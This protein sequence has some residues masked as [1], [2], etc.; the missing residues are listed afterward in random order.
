MK[1]IFSNGWI[2]IFHPAFGQEWSRLN[3]RYDLLK[4][5]LPKQKFLTHSDVKLL[6]ALD[7]GIREIIPDN[8]L[9]SD[10]ALHSS[11]QKY[12]RL[13]KKGL[14]GRYRLFFKVFDRERVEEK[15]RKFIDSI[16]NVTD[17]KEPIKGIIFI[18]WL[19]FPRKEGDKRDCYRVFKQK[20]K[21][22]EFSPSIPRLLEECYSQEDFRQEEINNSQE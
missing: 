11:L 7:R 2:I 21:N 20:V 12:S 9:H 14:P 16:A 5:R 10:F 4:K 18:L 19:G 22:G 8:P 13:K 1:P 17:H 6:A 3:E 15:Q